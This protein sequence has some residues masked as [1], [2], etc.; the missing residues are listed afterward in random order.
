MGRLETLHHPR[1]ISHPSIRWGMDD[2]SSQ[3]A[4]AWIGPV[5]RGCGGIDNFYFCIDILSVATR[6]EPK[7]PKDTSRIIGE[8][9]CLDPE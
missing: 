9:R 5:F 6:H 7:R 2:G 8:I 4:H 3:S 1:L